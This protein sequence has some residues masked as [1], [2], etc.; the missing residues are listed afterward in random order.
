[1]SNPCCFKP[2]EREPN[3][4]FFDQFMKNIPPFWPNNKVD[5]YIIN[6]YN[7]GESIDLHIVRLMFR[8]YRHIYNMSI[9]DAK[10]YVNKLLKIK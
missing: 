6:Q 8:T 3:D 5:E 10:K 1:M 7:K 4:P 9:D 2:L